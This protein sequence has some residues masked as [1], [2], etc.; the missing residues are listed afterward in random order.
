LSLQ[1]SVSMLSRS[2]DWLRL[3]RDDGRRVFDFDR[4]CDIFPSVAPPDLTPILVVTEERTSIFVVI[5][6]TCLTCALVLE[7]LDDVGSL[8]TLTLKRKLIL[9][10]STAVLLLIMARQNA[11]RASN[12][13]GV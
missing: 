3:H 5:I 11:Q 12:H 2:R 8:N 9:Y 1:P 13:S 6:V 4:L 10:V 7:G